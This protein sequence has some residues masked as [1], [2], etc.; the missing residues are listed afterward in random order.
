MPNSPNFRITEV[1]LED[2]QG[3]TKAVCNSTEPV[4]VSVSFRCF[5]TVRDLR[6]LAAIADENGS[7]FYG[8][9]N[10]DNVNIA[11]LFYTVEPG[12]YTAKCTLPANTLGNR[13]YYVNVDV[14][15]PKAEH[16]VLAKVL[17]FQ[18]EF[19]GYNPDIQYGSNDWGWF[20]CPKLSWSFRKTD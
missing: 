18:V 9:Q 14:L 12:E 19:N 11:K 16:H 20:V 13:K 6:V 8:S 1:R 7:A 4:V 5:K 15:S 17:E 2:T 10:T 3:T